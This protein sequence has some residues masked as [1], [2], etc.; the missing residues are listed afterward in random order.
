MSTYIHFTEQQKQQARQTEL[1]ELLRNQGEQLKRSGSEYE[2]RNGSEKVTIRGNLWFHQYERV[3][4]DAIDFVRKFYGTDYAGAMEYLLGSSSGVLKA[5]PTVQKKEK[6]PFSVPTANSN[7]RRVYAYLLAKRGIDKEVLDT[8]VRHGI[9][10]ESA[11][12]HNAVFVGKDKAGNP[13]HA[14]LRGTGTQSSYRGNQPNSIPEYSF[15]W[16]GTSECLY[17]FEAPIDMLSYISMHKENWQC[18]SY[19]AACGVSDRVLFRMLEDVP[20]I[21]K[22]YLCLDNDA[23]G[24]TATDK[25]SLK[26]YAKGIESEVLV[27]SQKDWNEDLLYPNQNIESEVTTSCQAL[28]L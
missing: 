20:N 8:F 13:C 25:I 4:G 23:A 3:G 16:N 24:Q 6:A 21:R 12:Y 22:V 7:M 5:A 11:K 14:S 9:I 17:L 28:R 26:L 19:A 1:C 27:P 2:W 10:Y 15:H 18:H